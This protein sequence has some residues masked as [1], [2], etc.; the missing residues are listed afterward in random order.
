MTAQVPA[1]LR[2]QLRVAARTDVGRVRLANEDAFVAADLSQGEAFGVPSWAGKLEVG[3]RGL[4]LAVSDGMG[5]L[6]AGEVASSMALSSLVQALAGRPPGAAGRDDL[7]GAVEVAHH[8]VWA[9]ACFR[10]IDM[11]ATLTAVHVRGGA[12][13]VAEVGDSRAYLIRGGRITQL[14]KDQSYVQMLVDAGA[15]TPDEARDFPERNV[16]LQAM[17]NQLDITVALGRLELRQLDCLL[18]CSDG[19][20]TKVTDDVMRDVVLTSPDLTVARDRLVDLANA[21]GGEDNTTVVL[22]GVSGDLPPPDVREPLEA[23]Y[24]IL[25]AFSAQTTSYS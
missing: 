1:P 13:Y 20:T 12:A 14:T 11:G 2:V 21:R 15:V 10:G 19:L 18:L 5:G 22:G 6:K 16:I 7:T 17:G 8:K 9:E 24:R 4:L 23:T 25:D 3:R